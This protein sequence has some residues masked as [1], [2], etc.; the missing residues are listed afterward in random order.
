M[1]A[2]QFA[3]RCRPHGA[4]TQPLPDGGLT[5]SV[6]YAPSV[7]VEGISAARLLLPG[8]RILPP[9]RHRSA[10]TALVAL[11][12]SAA[13]LSGEGMSP[14]LPDTGDIVYIP[15]GVSYAIVNLSLN[16]AVLYLMVTTDPALNSD[17]VRAPEHAGLAADRAVALRAEHLK[18]IM[19][20][21]RAKPRRRRH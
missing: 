7:P 4:D 13:V 16:A 18:R 20:S 5:T 8:A 14:V 3:V 9:Q 21:E 10:E 11:S 19:N 6:L 17:V 15:T 1:T 12:G 2:P